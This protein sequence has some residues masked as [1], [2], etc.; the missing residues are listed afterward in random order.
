VLGGK[1][2]VYLVLSKNPKNARLNVIH[3]N[4]EPAYVAVSWHYSSQQELENIS[5]VPTLEL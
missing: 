5:T 2:G 3:A 1:Y 4:E